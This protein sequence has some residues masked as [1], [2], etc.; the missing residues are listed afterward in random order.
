MLLLISGCASTTRPSAPHAVLPQPRLLPGSLSGG[1]ALTQE[2]H[3]ERLSPRGDIVPVA[4]LAALLEVDAHAV[5]LAGLLHGRRVLRLHWDG[6][7]LEVQQ[8]PQLPAGTD[9]ARILRDL[10]WVYWPAESLRATLPA[11]WH[12]HE[13]AGQRELQHAGISAWTVSYDGAT[14]VISTHLVVHNPTEGYRLRIHTWPS[15]P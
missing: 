9:P 2:L 5:R 1:L 7:R 4:S 8:D 14:P 3:F 13:H 10:Q 11:G 15:D 12:L 6:V